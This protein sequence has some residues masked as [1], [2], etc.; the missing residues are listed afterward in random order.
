MVK[1]AATG[2][3]S[4]TNTS[5]T[6]RPFMYTPG[7]EFRV[8]DIWTQRIPVKADLEVTIGRIYTKDTNGYIV[9]PTAASGQADLRRGVF[10]ATETWTNTKWPIGGFPAS[11]DP[12]TNGDGNRYVSFAVPTS[13]VVLYSDAD[14]YPGLMVD[15]A[16][17]G[18]AF[19]A[20]RVK[21]NATAARAN[22]TVGMC[23]D[24]LE[25]TNDGS[26]LN[27]IPDRR[28]K[29]KTAAGDLVLVRLGVGLT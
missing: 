20:D 12:S 8:G 2:T 13:F 11:D 29:A 17:A 1:I 3:T 4:A 6:I 16:A 14:V 21:A 24:I 15:M 18:T 27:A 9:A 7:N 26:A 22:G 19:T 10:Q 5:T 23:V 25:P 28:R